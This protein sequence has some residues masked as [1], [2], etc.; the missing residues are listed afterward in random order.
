LKQNANTKEVRLKSLVVVA[1]GAVLYA[2]YRMPVALENH[3]PKPD[4]GGE[5]VYLLLF[6]IGLAAV[7]SVETYSAW[8]RRKRRLRRDQRTSRRR[9]SCEGKS[10]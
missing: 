3:Q 9:K 6:T 8:N 2:V 5:I 1:C 10:T 4:S 7:I